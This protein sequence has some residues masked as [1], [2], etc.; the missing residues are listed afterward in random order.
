MKKLFVFAIAIVLNLSAISGTSQTQ[1]LK[2]LQRTMKPKKVKLSPDLEELLTQ[3]DEAR[4]AGMTLAELRQQRLGRAKG[5]RATTP[6]SQRQKI[7]GA[8]LPSEAVGEE[9]KQSFIVQLDSTASEVMWQEKVARLGGRINQQH[10]ELGLVTIEAPRAAIRQLAADSNIAYISPDRLVQPTGIVE[11]TTGTN[12]IRGLLGTKTS[13]DGKGIG[14]AILDSGVFTRHNAYVDDLGKNHVTFSKDFTGNNVTNQDVYGHGSHVATLAGATTNYGKGEYVGIA[15]NANLLNLRVLNNDG[16]GSAS[17]I[18][19][20]LDWCIANKAT[21]NI[22]V[23]NM[24]LGTYAKDSYKTDP[25]CRAARRA[26]NAGIVVVAAAGNSGKDLYGNK[27]YGGIHSP[28]IEPSVITVGASN[29]LGTEQRSDDVV[30]TFSSRGPTRGYA[31]VNGVRKYDNLI[32]PDLVAPGN[33]LIAAQSSGDTVQNN[34]L[35]RTVPALNTNASATAANRTMYL[36]GT[37]MSAP[38]VAGAAALLLQV[39]PNLTPGLVKAILMYTAQP[40]KNF[41]SL[42]QGAGLLNVDGAARMAK[43]I[44]PTAATL[45]NGATMITTA[46]LPTQTS[47]IAGRNLC[48]GQRRDYQSLLPLRR[49]ADAKLAGDVRTG[50]SFCRCDFHREWRADPQHYADF[51]HECDAW[52][53]RRCRQSHRRGVVRRC[54]CL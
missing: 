20:A 15:N 49:C 47:T 29:T 21:Y 40:L 18:I 50:G 48:L 23:I 37:S 6:E 14:I 2:D 27:I 41:N 39:N 43:L 16:L 25:L 44:K 35:I 54:G 9:E 36:S 17:T 24:S 1:T 11:K 26:Y 28:G 30:T 38:V 45:T 10:G 7:G 22:R 3:D 13:V 31:I 42:E 12:L 46:A 4:F 8:V 33:K 34:L 5:Q 19:A 32:K 52:H 51:R 53:Q